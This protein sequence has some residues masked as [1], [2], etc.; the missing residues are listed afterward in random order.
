MKFRFLALAALAATSITAQAGLTTLTGA[1]GWP[2]TGSTGLQAVQFNQVSSLGITVAT[3]AHA[4]KEGATLPNN[5]LDTY[6]A[7]SGFSPNPNTAYARWSLDYAIN[8]GTSTVG[9]SQTVFSFDIDPSAN[10]NFL[11]ITLNST[12][13]TPYCDS[14]VFADSNNPVFIY[15]LLNNSPYSSG[16]NF[17]PTAAG[18]YDFKVTVLRSGSDFSEVSSQIAVSISSVP[19]PGTLALLGVALA[20]MGAMRRRKV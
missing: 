7:N 2:P 13:C 3:G 12:N 20:G 6:F 15:G 11:N 14:N 17:D 18:V 19:E 9:Q 5:G 10:T 16:F 1:D 8:Y 4:Y